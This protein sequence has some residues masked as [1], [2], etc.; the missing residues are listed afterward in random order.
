MKRFV[1]LVAVFVISLSCQETENELTPQEPTEAVDDSRTKQEE[2]NES[3]TAKDQEAELSKLEMALAKKWLIKAIEDFFREDV[4]NRLESITTA[5]Y[6]EYKID[7]MNLAYDHGLSQAE[8][9]RKWKGTFD[10]SKNAYDKGFLI[11]AQD[12][13]KITVKKCDF[14]S[15]SKAG[16]YVF[17]VVLYDELFK[18]SYKSDVTVVPYKGSWAIGDVKDYFPR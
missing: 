10:V 8:F 18:S 4:I 6:A 14:L 9:E 13:G 16:G 5:S 11:D 3:I 7:A 2:N 17:Q 15:E 12:N 1:Y